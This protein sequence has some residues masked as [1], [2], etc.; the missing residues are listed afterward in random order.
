MK[1]GT[2]RAVLVGDLFHD[3]GPF[4]SV[5]DDFVAMRCGF[6]SHPVGDDALFAPDGFLCSACATAFAASVNT[7]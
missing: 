1:N 4:L 7:S 2:S 5:A 6:C 3:D